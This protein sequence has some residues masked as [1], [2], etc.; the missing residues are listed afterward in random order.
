MIAQGIGAIGS[1]FGLGKTANATKPAGYVNALTNY[2]QPGQAGA[3]WQYFDNG[4]AINAQGEYFFQGEKVWAPDAVAINPPNS[5]ADTGLW[6]D[7][8]F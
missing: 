7:L 6:T 8:G 3:G 1:L 4:T 2:S 5:Y